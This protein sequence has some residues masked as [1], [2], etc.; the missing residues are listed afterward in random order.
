MTP[1]ARQA[2]RDYHREYRKQHPEKKREYNSRYWEKKAQAIRA[3]QPAKD[4][5]AVKNGG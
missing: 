4:E 2:M 1:E 3:A 5:K